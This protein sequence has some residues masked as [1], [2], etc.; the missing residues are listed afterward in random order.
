M[1]QKLRFIGFGL[2]LFGAIACGK[3]PEEKSAEKPATTAA[4]GEKTVIQY[5]AIPNY[6]NWGGVTEAYFKKTGVRV[7]PDMKGSSAAM[8]ALEAEKDK[9]MADVVYY[10]GAIGYQAAGKGLHQP[11]KP[12]GWD[13]IP[14]N[15]KDPE[16]LWWTLHTAHI[17]LLVNTNALKGK[18]IPR[19]FADLLKPEYKGLVVYD[20][21]RIHGTAFTFV[22]GINQLM[23]GGADM[24]KGFEYL[25]K[26]HPNI[27]KYAKENSYN[28]LLRGEV[29]IWINADGNGF[30]AKHADKAPIEVVIP[31][32]GAIVMPLVMAMVKG[33]PRPEEAKKYLDW[34]LTEEAQKL[35]AEAFFQ[36]V[37][38]FDLPADL[39]S[40]FPPP[41]AYA[42][43]VVPKLSDMAAQADA[44]K[45]RWEQEIETAR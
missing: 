23:G 10:S 6:A 14:D 40:K 26:L 42:K 28:D 33:A 32:E 4:T 39:K 43:S 34:L 36:P 5:D 17:S 20:D 27:L 3:K 15:L 7:P 44:I 24:N 38:K 9:P 22:Y 12:A 35:M 21:P 18:P 41:A 37:V 45:K 11:Y 13:K 31:A 2:L 8:A 29:P 16:A 1:K 19:S 25:K 30:K